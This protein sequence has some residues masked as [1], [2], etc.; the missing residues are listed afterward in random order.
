MQNQDLFINS[1]AVLTSLMYLM[2]SCTNLFSLNGL[3]GGYSLY[4]SYF[5]NKAESDDEEDQNEELKQ[6]RN[7][8]YDLNG[9]T[10]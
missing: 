7:Q 10:K 4:Q 3:A 6:R 2:G 1:N 8:D 5:K 9:L